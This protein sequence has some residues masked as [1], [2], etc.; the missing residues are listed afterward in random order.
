M[1]SLI[2]W[3]IVFLISILILIKAADFFTDSA[4]KIGIHFGI[5]AFIVGVTI[6]SIGTSLP[7][8]ITS[9]IAVTQGVS[10]IVVANVLGSNITNIFLVLGISAIVAKRLKLTYE[11]IKI[12]LPLLIGSALFLTICIWDG[13]FTFIEAILCILGFITYIFYT[14]NVEKRHKDKEIKKELAG[15]LKKKKLKVKTWVI[16]ILSIGFIYFASKYTIDAVINISR[17]LNIGTEII[18]VS[19]VALGTSLP[20]LIV[21]LTAAFKGKPEMAIGNILGSNIFNGLAVV[22]IA[23]LFGTLIIP[24]SI[25][26]FALPMMLI[27]IFL[28]VFMTLGKEV[29]RWEGWFLILFY[30][31]FIGKLFGLF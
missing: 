2:I 8:L 11:I 5:P 3:I 25:I 17:I 10:E 1:I 29:S 23:G 30:I 9:V 16:L 19:A 24:A 21:S 18:A 6:V 31:L 4:E 22:G 15:A 26:S 20:E 12:D 27:A 7:E 13:A 28:F 14:I